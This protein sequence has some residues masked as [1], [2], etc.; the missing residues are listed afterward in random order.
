MFAHSNAILNDGKKEGKHWHFP[1]AKSRNLEVM[2][3]QN[4]KECYRSS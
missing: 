1:V 4:R 2:N 3:S